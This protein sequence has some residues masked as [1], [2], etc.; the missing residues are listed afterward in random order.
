MRRNSALKCEPEIYD[1][2]D[3]CLSHSIFNPA[4]KGQVIHESEFQ[5]LWKCGVMRFKM[6]R[7]LWKTFLGHRKSRKQLL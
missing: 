2:D 7:F 3:Y 4:T 5:I 6:V 1:E